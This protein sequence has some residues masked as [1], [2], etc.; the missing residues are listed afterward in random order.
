MNEKVLYIF[1]D[2]GGDLEFSNKGT[3]YFTLTA[4]SKIRPFTLYEPLV[5]L[6][7]D[8]W[9]K[10]INFEYF[11]A[12]EDTQRTRDEVFELIS[13]NLSK[14][15]I[16]SIIVEKGKTYP[17]LQDHHRFYQKTFQM[18]LNY[19]LERHK[20][21][22]NRIFILTDTI[23]V[24]KKRSEIQKAIKTFT[25]SWAM[26]YK[27]DYTVQHYASKSDINLQIVDYFNWAIFRKWERSDTRSYD[28]IKDA[29]FSEF[30][31]F[32]VGGHYYY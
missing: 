18:L 17:A 24:K 28:I 20:G 2:E 32:E 3:R 6:K 27:A 21:N 16:D 15:T 10:G 9:E 31:V 1:I 25:S 30:D 29:V 7:Y 22:F 12:T 8:L 13:N 4:L 14:F 23:P 26:K 5:N 11:H 19:T